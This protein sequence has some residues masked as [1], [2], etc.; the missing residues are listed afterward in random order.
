MWTHI[1]ITELE[2]HTFNLRKDE[3]KEKFETVKQASNGVPRL[4]MQQGEL[5][6]NDSN[7]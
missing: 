4:I 6:N 1:I 5:F 2:T 7:K 3:D